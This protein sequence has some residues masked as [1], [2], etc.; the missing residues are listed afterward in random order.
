MKNPAHK[1]KQTEIRELKREMKEQGVRVTSCMN[2]GLTG[3]EYS[4]NATLFRLKTELIRIPV[5]VAQ[6][7]QT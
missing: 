3:M 7:E 5:E 4:Y 2:G 6:V 1:A